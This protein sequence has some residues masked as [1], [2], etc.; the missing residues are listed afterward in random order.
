VT[1]YSATPEEMETI[2]ANGVGDY[3]TYQ[4]HNETGTWMAFERNG[5]IATVK[6]DKTVIGAERGLFE[7]SDTPGTCY[8]LGKSPTRANKIICKALGLNEDG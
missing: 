3:M 8:R 7:V 1:D 4:N 6:R 5:A 2:L